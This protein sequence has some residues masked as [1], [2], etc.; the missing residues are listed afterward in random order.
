[1]RSDSLRH[2]GLTLVPSDRLVLPGES[3][4]GFFSMVIAIYPGILGAF[5]CAELYGYLEDGSVQFATEVK[6]RLICSFNT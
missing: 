6:I 2:I 3:S 4:S 5:T 1:M